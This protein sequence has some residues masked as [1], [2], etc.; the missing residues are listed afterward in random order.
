MCGEVFFFF[1]LSSFPSLYLAHSF[2]PLPF[3]LSGAY[4][5]LHF[6]QPASAGP[7]CLYFVFSFTFA[8][9]SFIWPLWGI[10]L[11]IWYYLPPFLLHVLWPLRWFLC[12]SFLLSSDASSSLS[13]APFLSIYLYHFSPCR[14]CLYSMYITRALSL[15]Q[16]SERASLPFSSISHR[17]LSLF[18]TCYSL[19]TIR[20]FF[21]L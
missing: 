5:P 2:S 10:A 12:P 4:L 1:V 18:Y 7:D 13:L 15:S 3:L 17:P 20:L 6:I 9:R 21:N 14:F 19:A 11:I 8:F 16:G